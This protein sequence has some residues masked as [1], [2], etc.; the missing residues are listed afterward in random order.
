MSDPGTAATKAAIHFTHSINWSP[1][2]ANFYSSR[3]G[4]DCG[5]GDDAS[6][7]DSDEMDAT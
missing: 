5:C 1:M 6:A 2:D 3:R 7:G 4:C